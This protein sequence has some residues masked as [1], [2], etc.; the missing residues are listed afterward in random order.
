MSVKEALNPRSFVNLFEY[1][2]CA[3]H[4]GN[5]T[6]ERETVYLLNVW[7]ILGA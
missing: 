1:L 2:L 5:N 4:Q 3:R 6:D 7:H